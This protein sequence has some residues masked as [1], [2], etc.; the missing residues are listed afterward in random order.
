MEPK[1]PLGYIELDNGRKAIYAMNDF[2]LNFI[3]ANRDNWEIFRLMLN[4]LLEACRKVNPN[5]LITLIEGAIHI[6][7]QY[8]FYINAQHNTRN[9]DFKIV[10]TEQVKYVEFQNR[11][12]TDPPIPNRAIEYFVLGIGKSQGQIAN[13]IWLLGSDV[14]EVLHGKTFTNYILKDEITNTVY[15]GTS[16]ILFISLTQLSKE[17]SLA[18]ELALFLLGKTKNFQHK[19]V[20]CIAETFNTSFAT[21]RDDKEVK[22]AMTME[23]KWRKESWLDGKEEGIA[24]NM[25]MTL[26][27][28]GLLKKNIPAT[29]IAR[30]Y[31]VSTSWVE[32]LRTAL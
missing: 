6:E 32:Q 28:L 15:P 7:T 27:I 10:E 23:Q 8:T 2:L 21:F 5:S 3:F 30:Q 26:K 13:Q 16:G 17:K 29:E 14:D 1:T 31:E 12:T 25:D 20:Q 19:E 24:E 4:I 9:Q 18:G 22:K 11:A